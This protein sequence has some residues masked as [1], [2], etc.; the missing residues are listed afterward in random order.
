MRYVQTHYPT[1]YP[2]CEQLL[3]KNQSYKNEKR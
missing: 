3:G 1:S 2:T